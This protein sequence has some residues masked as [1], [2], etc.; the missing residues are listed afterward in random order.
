MYMFYL[1]V[2]NC[3]HFCVCSV[4]LSLIFHSA[5]CGVSVGTELY[6]WQS[7]VCLY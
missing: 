4:G 7:G 6:T 2:L 1:S 5:V 3:T